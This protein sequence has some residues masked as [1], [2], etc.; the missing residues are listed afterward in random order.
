MDCPFDQINDAKIEFFEESK[1]ERQ[2][3]E[4]RSQTSK[5]FVSNEKFIFVLCLMDLKS[6]FGVKKK[7]VWNMTI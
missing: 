4:A 2:I 1:I 5:V 6:I 3:K 7:K